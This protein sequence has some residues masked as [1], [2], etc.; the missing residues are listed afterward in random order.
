MKNKL[1]YLIKFIIFT[2]L[3]FVLSRANI[4]GGI[5]PF[6]FS[7]LFALAWANQKV[8]ILVPSYIIGYL[9]SFHTLNDVVIVL[10]TVAMLI[11]PY[12]IHVACKKP[13]KKWEIFLFA[14]ISQTCAIVFGILNLQNPIFISLNIVL[15][16]IFLYL[17]I[18][19]FEALIIRGFSSKLTLFELICGAL[20]LMA[21]SSGL[22]N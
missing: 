21:I 8:W 3:F 22:V 9:A 19:I 2:L 15:G 18:V 5:Y 1:I 12:Y 20:I 16:E 17:A 6:S 14:L 10:T 13:M 11:I 4:S 7:M